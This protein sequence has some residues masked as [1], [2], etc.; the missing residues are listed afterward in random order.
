MYLFI[1]QDQATDFLTGPWGIIDKIGNPIT[2]AAF[3]VAIVIAYYQFKIVQQRKLIKNLPEDKKYDA[4]AEY[5]GK[6][7][8]PIEDLTK[9]QRFELAMQTLKDKAS[10]RRNQI[11]LVVFISTILGA[12]AYTANKKAVKTEIPMLEYS[13][14]YKVPSSKDSIVTR[15]ITDTKQHRN[16]HCSSATNINWVIRSDSNEGW[17]IIVDSIKVLNVSARSNDVFNGIFDKASSGFS[18]KGVVRNSGRCTPFSRDA[19][20]KL[21][22][23]YSYIEERKTKV[24]ALDDIV[25]KGSSVFGNDVS[26]QLP[27]NALD[28]DVQIIDPE[29]NK[30]ELSKDSPSAGIFTIQES[31]GSLIIKSE[32]DI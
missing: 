30:I 14:N 17:K 10:H 1:F 27:L 32:N 15:K 11:F 6:L 31:A 18:L 28:Y 25:L 21:V 19:R 2:L 26:V 8:I 22:V 29:K 20:G 12:L 4:A 23:T 24:E 7:G 3:I 9:Q 5:L 13:I 16:G